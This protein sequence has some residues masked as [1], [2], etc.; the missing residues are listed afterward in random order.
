MNSSRQVASDNVK[1]FSEKRGVSCFSEDNADL[2][3]WS[4]YGE[5]HKGFCLEFDTSYFSKFSK[6]KYSA[7]MPIFDPLPVLKHDLEDNDFMSIFSTKSLSWSYEKEWRLL[8]AEANKFY[9]YPREALTGV[10]FGPEIDEAALE[11]ICLILQGQNERVLFWK[12]SRNSKNFKVD[13]KQFDY[14]S[15]IDFETTSST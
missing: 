4:H 12:G 15:I 13:F 6:V 14:K 1:E 10:Y 9:H 7:T 2:L 11:I 3:M 8:H 5:N